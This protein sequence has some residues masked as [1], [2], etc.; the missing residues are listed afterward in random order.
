MIRAIL[1]RWLFSRGFRMAASPKWWKASCRNRIGLLSESSYL[2]ETEKPTSFPRDSDQDKRLQVPA[3]RVSSRMRT[4]LS[5]VIFQFIGVFMSDPDHPPSLLRPLPKSETPLKNGRDVLR[6][7]GIL[8]KL[9]AKIIQ[10]FCALPINK[11]S[12]TL[13]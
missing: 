2:K 1:S 5:L 9:S 11:T 3:T 4:P 8:S 6:S 10:P 13:L 7:I 12:D